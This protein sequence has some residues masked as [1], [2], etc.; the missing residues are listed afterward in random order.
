[1][2]MPRSLS[3]IAEA[4][5]MAR[6]I[7]YTGIAIV[8][9]FVVLAIFAPWIAPYGFDQVSDSAGRFP[10]QAPPD[11]QHLFGTTVQSTD[12]LSRVIWG[13]RTAIEVVVLAVALSL[14]VG[15]PLGLISGYVGGK[16]QQPVPRDVVA[17]MAPTGPAAAEVPTHWNVNFWVDDADATVE[18]A[19]GAGGQVIM[20]PMD[21]PG[22]RNA[23][24]ADP[25]G[26]AFSISQLTAG[27]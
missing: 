26:A 18:Q 9:L 19:A 6:W 8:V 13:S 22:F 10:K 11:S 12:V 5:G 16:P 15:V 27:P 23:V 24:V 2:R 7:L 17:V 3:R 21:T 25:Q 1:M 14:V 20:P 4:R